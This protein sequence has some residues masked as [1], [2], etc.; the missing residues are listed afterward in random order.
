LLLSLLLIFCGTT[1]TPGEGV[2]VAVE[3]DELVDMSLRRS[4]LFSE[5]FLK[6]FFLPEISWSWSSE[7][8][9]V[10]ATVAVGLS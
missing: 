7:D 5:Y 3:V 9:V 6:T 10:I 2:V 8:C 1:K 4:Y